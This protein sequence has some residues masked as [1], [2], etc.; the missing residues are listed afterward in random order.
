ML[1]CLV[2]ASR[3]GRPKKASKMT[4]GSLP[5]PS[6]RVGKSTKNGPKT[7]QKSS[8]TAPRALRTIFHLPL[9]H[10]ERPPGADLAPMTPQE[11][12][13]SPFGTPGGRNL[14]PGGGAKFD[15]RSFFFWTPG[16]RFLQPPA[17][18]F[19]TQVGPYYAYYV[20]ENWPAERFNSPGLRPNGVSDP[21]LS[22]CYY[23]FSL[24]I[25]RPQGLCGKQNRLPGASCEARSC[26]QEGPRK[27]LKACTLG[28]RSLH[29]SPY[30][31][32]RNARSD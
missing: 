28:R 7:R 10:P 4:S 8:K 19:R 3:P 16:R 2:F 29:V 9:S 12:F 11:G 24:I 32:R 6:P 23:G 31:A 15:P 22:C 21:E 27:P 1:N 26:Q 17:N 14:T 5:G 25:A 30:L 13:R 18:H 20:V